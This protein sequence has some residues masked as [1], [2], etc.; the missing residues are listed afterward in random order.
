MITGIGVDIVQNSRFDSWK[1]F[2]QD[3]LRRVFSQEEIEACDSVVRLATYFAAKEAFFKALS[4]TLVSLSMTNQEFSL[5][6]LCSCVEV[7]K[8]TWDVPVLHV[9]WSVIERKIEKKLPDLKV[10]LSLSHEKEYSIAYVLVS[11]TGP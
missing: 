3:Q 2:S 8:I 5:L 11:T 7:K 4:A 6:F 9:N 10:E 1:R